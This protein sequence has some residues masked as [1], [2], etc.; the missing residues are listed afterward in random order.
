MFDN[1]YTEIDRIRD[2]IARG[3][4]LIPRE[5]ALIRFWDRMKAQKFET[6]YDH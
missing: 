3:K 2:K 5:N 1:E 4:I 6:E